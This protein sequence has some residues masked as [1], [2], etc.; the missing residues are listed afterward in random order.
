M[1]TC[2]NDYIYISAFD[3]DIPSPE[4]LTVLLS[5]RH[6]AIG[7]DGVVVM[8]RSSVADAKM[9]M[10]NKDGSEGR[11]SGNAIRCVAK[12]LYDNGIVRK[13]EMTIETLSGVKTLSFV[14][15]DD[16]V[17]RVTADMGKAVLD[18]AEVPVKLD[19]ER[20]INRKVSVADGEYAITCVSMGNPHCVV[21]VDET[22]DIDVPGIGPKFEYDPLFP[23]RVNT[24]FVQVIDERTLKMRVW[25]RG[26]GETLA[27][28]TGACA[29]VVA[30]VENGYCTKGVDI[31]VILLGGDLIVRYTD[32]TVLM[33]GETIKVYDGVVEI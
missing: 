20:V 25:E 32:D 19:G 29:A 31:R 28:G 23:E 5:D 24:E 21:F 10:Y 8:D 4:S 18:A 17:C 1:Q 15:H 11:M 22:D 27:C 30:A 9:R 7:G 12:Y 33:T 2:G 26:N 16:R 6:F 13:R 3:Q 14:T